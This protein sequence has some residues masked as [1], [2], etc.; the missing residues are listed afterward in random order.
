MALPSDKRT[1]FT[2][3]FLRLSETVRFL[4]TWANTHVALRASEQTVLL[5]CF[6][7]MRFV[8]IFGDS[9]VSG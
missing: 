9:G 2:C 3:A 5:E 6:I 8:G 7:R 1:P 4:H